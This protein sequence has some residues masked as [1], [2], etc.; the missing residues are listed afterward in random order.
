MPIKRRKYKQNVVYSHKEHNTRRTNS[1]RVLTENS[2][3]SSKLNAEWKKQDFCATLWFHV[4]EVQKQVELICAV[5]RQEGLLLV[6]GGR[7]W[8]TA[9]CGLRTDTLF[10]GMLLV[11]ISE[12]LSSPYLCSLFSMYISI[13]NYQIL[14]M[15]IHFPCF[16]VNYLYLVFFNLGFFF[17]WVG[18]PGGSDG[19][20]KSACNA[21]N[22]GRIPGWER[23]LEKGMATHSGILA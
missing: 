2:V 15:E 23:S 7:H 18:F 21:G 20:T 22:L 10:L 11:V 9:Q 13:N 1:L 5:G 8:K 19:K 6:E 14:K 3:D 12:N 4:D 17:F 16:F